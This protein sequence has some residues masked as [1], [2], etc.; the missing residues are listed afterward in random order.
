ME[1]DYEVL[2]V[3][4]DAAIK[5]FEDIERRMGK[6]PHRDEAVLEEYMRHANATGGRDL[7]STINHL[8]ELRDKLVEEEHARRPSFGGAV[9]APCRIYVRMPAGG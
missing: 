5:H 1:A 3:A 4:L 7:T 2:I 8:M 9:V 6:A